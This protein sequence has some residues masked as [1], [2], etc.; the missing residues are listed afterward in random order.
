MRALSEDAFGIFE[1][2]GAALQ[3][4]GGDGARLAHDL[5]A[6]L[7]DGRAAQG[8]GPRVEG[9]GSEGNRLRVALHDFDVAEGDSERA[10]GD[11]REAR[12]MTLPRALGTAEHGGAAVRMHH[13]ARALVTGAL[14]S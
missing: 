6:R 11:L 13:H 7:V 1:V 9:A 5:A 2:V 12:R 14:Q 8:H 4:V 3:L 10:G